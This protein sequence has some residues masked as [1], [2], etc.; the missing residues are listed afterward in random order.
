[1]VQN[2]SWEANRFAA[3]QETPNILWN[4]KV[5]YRF[6]KCPPPVSILSQ[7]NPVHIPHPTSRRSILI[8]SSHLR[9][10]SSVVSFPQVSPPKPCTRLSPPQPRYMP[11]PPH[12]SRFYHPHNIHKKYSGVK[13]T[14]YS[15]VS[16]GYLQQQRWIEE[17]KYVTLFH[18]TVFHFTKFDTALLLLLFWIF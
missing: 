7:L 15:M 9:L 8:L 12:S 18:Y 2:P 1:M 3:S 16:S 11:C 13:I 14:H 6:H 17:W 4:P 10:V 5:H